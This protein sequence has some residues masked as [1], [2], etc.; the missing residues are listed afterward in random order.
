M[1]ITPKIELHLRK[2]VKSGDRT[3]AQP[4]V[5]NEV[6]NCFELTSSKARLWVW[7]LNAAFTFGYWGFLVAQCFRL[8][9]VENTPATSK[10]FAYTFA[11]FLIISWTYH[12]QFCF[13]LH[14]FPRFVR[15]FVEYSG[16]IDGE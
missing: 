3:G 5:W 14:S 6:N 13:H 12:I 9:Y 2:C 4:Y 11:V 7:Y 1:A 10:I 8:S 15:E 16:V